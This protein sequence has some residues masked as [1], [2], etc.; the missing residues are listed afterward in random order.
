MK[1]AVRELTLW[2]LAI[3]MRQRFKHAAAERETASPLIVRVELNN[4]VQGYGETHPRPYVTGEHPDEVYRT[5]CNDFVPDLVTMAPDSFPAALEAIAALPERAD[6]GRCVTATRAAI[7]LALLD[8]YSRAFKRPLD[9]LAAWLGDPA[10]GSGGS[11]R[12]VR[13]SGVLSA[14]SPAAV[15]RSLFKMRLYGLRDF[16]VKV[17]DDGDDPRLRAAAAYLARP[18]RA[19]RC[20]LRVDANGAWTASQ[21]VDRLRAWD[22][23]GLAAV[24]QPLP[25]SAD[26]ELP[27][28][29][30]ASSIP[31]MADESLVTTD[32]AERLIATRAVRAF[33]IRLA[34]NGGLIPSIRMARMAQ[35]AGLMVQLGCLVGETSLLSAAGRWFLQLVPGVRFAEGSYGRFLLRGDIV[36]RPVQFGYGARAK[37]LGGL[38]F[39]VHVEEELLS[40]F[41]KERPVTITL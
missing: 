41:C 23:L 30:A 14:D 38:G 15:R 26:A 18:I 7:E 16:K 13:Y 35:R 27:A 10:L 36:G 21:A 2:T 24:E 6:D 20:S 25:A 29:S 3:P 34:K 33:N 11:V 8:A 39:G 1:T 37:P 12:T 4:G 19:G 9:V 22:A 28:L 31:L 17:G 32:D 40:E 5:I